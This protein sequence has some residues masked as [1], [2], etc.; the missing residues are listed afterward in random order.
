MTDR[1][2][3]G[4][5]SVIRLATDADAA[6]IASIYAPVVRDT[7]VSFEMA[8]PSADVMRQRIRDVLALAPWLVLE[9]DGAVLGYAYAGS[10][11]TR[12]AY[13]FTVETTVYVAS[14]ARGRKV[15]RRL[16]DELLR[17]VRLQGFRTAVAGITLPNPASVALHESLGF[18]P[19]GVYHKVGFKLG[20]WHDV[21]W[22]ELPIGA[23][24]DA[25]PEPS[26]LQGR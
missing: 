1:A 22:W 17:R 20:A 24:D 14:G 26:P 18:K 25:P 23:Y 15:G 16:Y 4:G 7:A 21:G 19:V 3:A 12:P 13:R 5:A 10:F 6:A 9:E 2:K 8:P 11:R